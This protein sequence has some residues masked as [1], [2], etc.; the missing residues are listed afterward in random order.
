M[1]AKRRRRVVAVQVVK[2][3]DIPQGWKLMESDHMPLGKGL[4]DLTSKTIYINPQDRLGLP[5]RDAYVKLRK[6]VTYKGVKG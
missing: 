3:V 1:F 5:M 6:F 2:V 4:K